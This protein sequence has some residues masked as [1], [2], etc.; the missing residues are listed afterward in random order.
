M[1]LTQL[2]NLG[3]V[4]NAGIATTKLGAGAVLQVVMGTTSTEASSSSTIFADTNLT[5]T[6][7]PSA[8]S[9][10]VLVLVSQN[11][12]RK[13][14]GDSNNQL[15]L[16]LLRTSTDL[17][18]FCTQ[19]GFTQTA[20]FNAFGSASCEYLDSPNTTSATTY[21]TQLA[22]GNASA[23]VTVQTDSQSTSTITLI[24]IAG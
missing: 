2:R 21:K 22:N 7:T 4:A 16:K 18:T 19:G 14:N 5:A 9:S 11:G 1:S 24:E 6:I 10:K 13:T 8:T 3:I 15:I 12:C 23:A 17:I 20:N